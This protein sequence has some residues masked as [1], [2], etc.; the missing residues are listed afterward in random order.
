M[1][2]HGGWVPVSAGIVRGRRVTSVPA[3]R[4][5]LVNAGAEW[6]DKEVVRDGSLISSRRP[7]DLPAFCR[8]LIEALE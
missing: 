2:C 3:I 7:D 6:V 8:T 5:D 4:D 1:I